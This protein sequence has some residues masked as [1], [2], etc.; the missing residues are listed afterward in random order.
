MRRQNG[1][2]TISS[3]KVANKCPIL[4]IINFLQALDILTETLAYEKYGNI[5]TTADR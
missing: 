2:Q 1:V 4:F 3:A 5:Q